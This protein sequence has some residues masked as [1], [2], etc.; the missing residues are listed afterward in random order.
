M[1]AWQRRT[2]DAADEQILAMGMVTSDV[3]LS[4]MQ[5]LFNPVFFIN[6]SLRTICLWCMSYYEEYQRAPKDHIQDIFNERKFGI[7]KADAK[8]IEEFLVILNKRFVDFEGPVNDDYFLSRSKKYFTKQNLKVR[9]ERVRN[10][11]ELD[12]VDEAEAEMSDYKEFSIATSPAISPFDKELMR[13]ILNKEDRSLFHYPGAL[14]EI[15][16]PI[17]RG[18][19]YGVLGLFKRGKTF[20]VMNT[21]TLAASFRRNSLIVSL[22]MESVRIAER[23]IRNVGTFTKPKDQLFPCFDC[24]KNQKGTCNKSQRTNEHLLLVNGKKPRFDLSMVYKPCTVCRH[25]D[26]KEFEVATWFEKID[27]PDLSTKGM[28]KAAGAFT[29]MFGDNIRMLTY[30]KYTAN[31][32]DIERDI[33]LLEE[34]EM[35]IPDVICVAEG[36]L[37][38]TDSG[39]IPIEKITKS[40]RL[41]D[42]E[43]WVSHRG[44]IY[45][46]IKE[47]IEY[48]GLTATPEHLVRTEEGWRTLESCKKM[49]LRIVQTGKGR[50]NIWLGED[51]L[52]SSTSEKNSIRK[53]GICVYRMYTMRFEKMGLIWEFIYGKCK[54]MSCMFATKKIPFLVIQKAVCQKTTLP[55][56]KISRLEPLWRTGNRVSFFF[57]CRSLF[58]G[59]AK[60][61]FCRFITRIRQNRQRWPLRKR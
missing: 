17:E 33:R 58:M 36:S 45:K 46:G 37:V 57:S 3:F 39:L 22:E 38:L 60:S 44:I 48:E 49:G 24:V 29:T 55:K 53:K 61:W 20:F 52:T 14:G 6:D 41:W 2:V 31:I 25:I 54:R 59:Y 51:N 1:S 27:Y 13:R 19:L 40:H 12:K 47:V 16:G 35:F 30:P 42:G 23:I 4:K 18:C 50:K 28:N 9:A 26:P 15:I 21:L 56:S 43:N 10:F 5:D 7:D 8:L 11:L 32:R 34:K